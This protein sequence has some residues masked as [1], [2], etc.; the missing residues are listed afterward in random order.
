[1]TL[2]EFGNFLCEFSS[3]LCTVFSLTFFGSSAYGFAPASLV[4]PLGAVA[5]LSNVLISPVMLGEQFYPSDIGGI[6]LA[7]IGAVT[8]VFSSKQSDATLSPDE[9]LEAVKQKGF[10]AYVVIAI[11]L[12]ASLAWAS[13]TRLGQRWILLDVGV[14]AVLG[15]FT[16]LSTKG[17]SSLLSQGKPLELLHYPIT[18]VMVVVLAGTALA[19]ITYLNRALQRFDSREVIVSSFRAFIPHPF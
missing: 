18:Y 7:I 12:A 19:Q 4:A 5:L 15:G 17:L 1:M 10:I 6:I 2:G 16:V 3:P 14:C 9:L 11:V 13:T 8:V